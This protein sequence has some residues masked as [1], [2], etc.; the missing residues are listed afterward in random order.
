M[1][2]GPNRAA[3]GATTRK[4]EDLVLLVACPI[5]SWPETRYARLLSGCRHAGGLAG[6]A[7]PL[8]K[9][10]VHRDSED[11]SG[12]LEVEVFPPQLVL[13]YDGLGWNTPA[14]LNLTR[15]RARGYVALGYL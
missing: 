6:I 14:G 5:R 3:C 1:S 13:V 8:S 11:T 9:C 4:L 12:Y 7:L 2:V 10:L 15:S